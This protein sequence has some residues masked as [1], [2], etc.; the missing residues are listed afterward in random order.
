MTA[1]LL[2]KVP[3]LPKYFSR[4]PGMPSAVCA[5]RTTVNRV[6]MNAGA[7]CGLRTVWLPV[8]V[9]GL[10]P[11]ILLLAV[12]TPLRLQPNLFWALVGD[13]HLMKTPVLSDGQFLTA[14]AGEWN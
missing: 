6:R 9:V 10:L 12:S 14:H 5:V 4:Y 2:Q 13:L 11:S 8:P 7:K 1:L 3:V